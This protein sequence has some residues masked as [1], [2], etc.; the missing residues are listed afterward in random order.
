M[1]NHNV[2]VAIDGKISQE[3]IQ[4]FS[5]LLDDSI[6]KKYIRKIIHYLFPFFNLLKS[7]HKFF[8]KRY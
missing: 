4:A 2:W 6:H 7:P 3:Q 1:I 5:A 8:R